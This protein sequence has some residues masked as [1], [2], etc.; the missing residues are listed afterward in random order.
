MGWQEPHEIQQMNARSCIWAGLM[1]S[2]AAEKELPV[3][4]DRS[5]QGRTMT[6]QPA[7]VR[8][9]QADEGGIMPLTLHLVD[10]V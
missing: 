1:D 3:L 4:G 10:R 9:Q 6:Y 7:P 8:L 2:G 5:T